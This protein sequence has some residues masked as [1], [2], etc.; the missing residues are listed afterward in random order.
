MKLKSKR[1]TWMDSA[2][3]AESVPKKTSKHNFWGQVVKHILHL[4]VK[5]VAPNRVKVALKLVTP[6]PEGG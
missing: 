2:F 3:V 1:E 4:L 6:P 5:Q